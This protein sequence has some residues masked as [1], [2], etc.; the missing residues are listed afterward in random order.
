MV[1][2]N[3]KT[4]TTSLNSQGSFHMNSLRISSY[5]IKTSRNNLKVPVINDVHL[6]SMYNPAK[7]AQAIVSKHDQ[8]LATKKNVLV[9]GLGFAYHVYEICR[10]LESY[11]GND[12]KVVVIEPNEQIY[13][14]CISNHLFP[15]KNI[16]VYTGENLQKIYGELSLV[17]FLIEKPAVISHPSSFN[18]YSG[19]FKSFL[20]FEAS[21]DV[22]DLTKHI[23][24]RDLKSYLYQDKNSENLDGFIMNNVLTKSQFNSDIDHLM[25]AYSHLSNGEF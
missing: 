13:R 9:L 22:E 16:E 2:A 4:H 21:Q 1:T 15:N 5:E 10:K 18:L 12:Y 24:D 25:L 6:H 23:K 11:H 19:F 8:A 7:E 3:S 17:K 20:E 14:D